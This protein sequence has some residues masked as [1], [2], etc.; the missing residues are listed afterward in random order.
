MAAAFPVASITK[1]QPPGRS[2]SSA[3]AAVREQPSLLAVA[4]RSGLMSRTSTAAAPVRLA[5]SSIMSPMVPE[6]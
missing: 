6:P 4:S 5:S 3:E 2:N 1:S